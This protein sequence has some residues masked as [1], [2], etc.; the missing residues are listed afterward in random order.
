MDIKAIQALI[1][2]D[3][4][5]V[6]QL[7]HAQMRSDVA[8]VNQLGLYIVSSGGKRVR[9]MLAILAAKA[10]GYQGKDHITLATI[11][12]FIHTAT[13]LHD[14]VV[15][16]SNLRRGTPTANAEFGNAASVLVGDF[17]YTR[18]FQLMVGLGKM[19]VMQVLADATNIIAEGEVL[20]L[21]NCNDPDTTEASYMQV[22]YSKTA[23]LFEAATGLAAIITE[24]DQ[25]TLD[26]LNL[27]GMHLGTAFQLVDDVL[28]YNADAEQLG[29]NI[30]DDLAEGKPTLPLIYAMQHGSEQQTQLIRDAI[31]HS[32][33]MEHLEEILSALKQTNA[34]EFTMQKAE[35]EA[36]KAIACLDFL[37]E[38]DYKQA[39]ISLARIAVD[40]D[41]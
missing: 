27:Y 35:L 10:L 32:N 6:N 9:P 39:L 41:H 26:A 3:M 24:Q 38:S 1:E 19:Q 34:L 30:G 23:K 37:A 33:G 7:I 28:D 16:E 29:K 22:I 31:E 5:D 17:I 4:N 20:Q 12:E 2:S 40:R 11:V 18:S 14:D 13:L 36:D 15:D 8:L 25:S 21:M